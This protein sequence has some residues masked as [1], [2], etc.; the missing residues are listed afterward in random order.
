MNKAENVLLTI[1][2]PVFNEEATLGALYQKIAEVM[3]SMSST[4]Y[5]IIFID[6][7]STDDSWQQICQVH[8]RAPKQVRG[9]KFRKSICTS[10]GVCG[11]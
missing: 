2:I 3:N 7:G 11:V 8:S 4:E 6:D 9:F 5:E 10:F 1:V